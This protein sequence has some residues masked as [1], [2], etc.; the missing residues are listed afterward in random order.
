MRGAGEVMRGGVHRD[1]QVQG[2][3]L[4][5]LDSRDA[6]AARIVC[7]DQLA[8]I[9]RKGHYTVGVTDSDVLGAAVFIFI[10]GG[11]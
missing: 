6:D 5:R 9:V 8:V 11:V 3:A 10:A 1:L 4:R 7:A 2:L